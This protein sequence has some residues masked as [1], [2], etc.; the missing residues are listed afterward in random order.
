MFS[1]FERSLIC[2]P[3]L[4]LFAKKYS[5]NSNI[6]KYYYN[7]ILIIK[8]KFIPVIKAEFSHDP[9]EIIPISVLKPL[10]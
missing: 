6:M 8:M 5:K 1:V 3:R 7:Y 9:S 2:S 10:I 4:H